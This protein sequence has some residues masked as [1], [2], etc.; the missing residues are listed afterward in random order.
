[1][2]EKHGRRGLGIVSLGRDINWLVDDAQ[3]FN[4]KNNLLVAKVLQKK[5][6]M[7]NAYLRL[8]LLPFLTVQEGHG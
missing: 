5:K 7:G 2:E 8:W 3:Q 4:K 1:M 6:S